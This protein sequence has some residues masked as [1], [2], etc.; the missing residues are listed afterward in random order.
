MVS[1]K[2][3]LK[4]DSFIGPLLMHRPVMMSIM[5]YSAT[6]Q[7]DEHQKEQALS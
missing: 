3:S 2:I 5:N 7:L 6:T 4:Q 1:L